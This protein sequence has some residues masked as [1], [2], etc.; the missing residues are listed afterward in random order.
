MAKTP[1]LYHQTRTTLAFVLLAIALTC[2][3][4][5]ALHFRATM[6]PE[7]PAKRPISVEITSFTE[8]MTY[9]REVSYLGLVKASRSTQVGFEFGGRVSVLRVSEGSLVQ[10]GDILAELDTAKLKAQK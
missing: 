10:T 9:D 2:G 4:S 8:Q 7:K 3:L 6:A 1:R 5:W